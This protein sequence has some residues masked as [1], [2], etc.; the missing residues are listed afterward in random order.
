MSSAHALQ[1]LGHALWVVLPLMIDYNRSPVTFVSCDWWLESFFC[2]RLIA[3][4]SQHK[5]T[6]IVLIFPWKHG[7]ASLSTHNICFHGEIRKIFYVGSPLID[8]EQWIS[9][10]KRTKLRVNIFSTSIINRWSVGFTKPMIDNEIL[11]NIPKT[12]SEL[13]WRKIYQAYIVPLIL[14]LWIN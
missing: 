9:T 4:K 8:L 6:D 2:T 14:A 1:K 12:S 3:L 7:S 11:T 5:I 13:M 10:W